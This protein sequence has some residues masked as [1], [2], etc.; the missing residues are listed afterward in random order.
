MDLETFLTTLYVY[1]DDWY[2]SDVQQH[3][4]KHAGAE[5][6]LSDS[7]VLTIA[8]AG[9]WRVGVP[10]ASERGVVRW[11]QTQG[12]GLFPKMIKRSAFN[13][14]VRWLWGSFIYLQQAL[15]KVMT[16]P[17]D[18]YECVDCIGI[19][20]HSNAQHV[21]E[22]GHWL[23][24][25]TMAKAGTNGGFYM[26]DTL[27]VSVLPH[28]AITG[29]LLGSANVDDRWLLEALLS[30]RV[31]QPCLVGPPPSTHAAKADRA[32]PP[33][34]HVGMF[35]AVGQPRS[36]TYLADGGFSSYRWLKHWQLAYHAQVIA[37]SPGN[38]RLAWSAHT[39]RWLSSHRQV[40]ETVFA[41]LTDVFG[42]KHLAAHSRW[43]QYTRLAAKCAAFNIG[44]FFN[45]LLGRPLFALA[46]L[47]N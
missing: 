26:G 2:K 12:R 7:E 4:I 6:Q 33:I 41:I 19:P 40:V 8:L 29:W 36:A 34:A 46:T 43:G 16:S 42:L 5:A 3:I 31:G 37:P 47:I 13:E 39:R 11:M 14:R 24:E 21:R 27:L 45:R 32:K 10:W 25:S 9:Q 23:W 20:A 15:A 30:A 18:V 28:G 35:Q 17:Q 44:L 38:A 22:K 1:V